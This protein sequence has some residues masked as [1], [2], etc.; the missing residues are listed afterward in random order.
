MSGDTKNIEDLLKDLKYI[1]FILA[2]QIYS[3]EKS[4]QNIEKYLKQQLEESK[5]K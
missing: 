3:C 1:Y 5:G 2:D 4:Y